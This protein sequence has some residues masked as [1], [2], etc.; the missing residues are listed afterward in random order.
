MTK[1]SLFARI[2]NFFA[3]A[4][5]LSRHDYAAQALHRDAWLGK[6]T[7]AIRTPACFYS[8]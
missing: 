7:R 6:Q 3:G 1:T 4:S 8:F 2:F 5:T